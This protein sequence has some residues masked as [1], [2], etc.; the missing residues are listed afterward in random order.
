MKDALRGRWRLS[1]PGDGTFPPSRSPSSASQAPDTESENEAE[2]DLHVE[3]EGVVPRYTYKMQFG[4]GSSSVGAA[5]NTAVQAGQGGGGGKRGSRNN[6]L[7]WK[8]FWSYNRLTDDWGEFGLRND[9]AFYF[10]RVRSYG[11]GG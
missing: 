6:R 2:G 9:R 11:V 10:S 4:I 5:A 7:Q 1:G 8:G 3:T